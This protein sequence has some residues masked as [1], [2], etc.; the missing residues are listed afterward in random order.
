MRGTR[1]LCLAALVVAAGLVLPARARAGGLLAHWFGNPDCP[2]PSYSPCHYWT[3]AV[4]RL[5]EDH[6][7]PALHPYA[8]NT[9]PDIPPTFLFY[10]YRCPTSSPTEQMREYYGMQEQP[11]QQT[12][13][14]EQQQKDKQPQQPQA[15]PQ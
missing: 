11:Q 7:G 12:Q 15:K 1:K 6:H 8:P 2:P 13:Q 10:K 9:H 4:V 14:P 3:P 5:Y